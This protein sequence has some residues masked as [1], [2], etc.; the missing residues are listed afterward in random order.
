MSSEERIKILRDAA[1]M[2]WIAFSADESRIIATA[3]TYDQVIE[4]AEAEG[5]SEPVIVLTPEHW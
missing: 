3:K 4:K 5:E 2:T 1:P